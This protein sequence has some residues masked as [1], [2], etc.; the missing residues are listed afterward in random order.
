MVLHLCITKDVVI[1]AGHNSLKNRIQ[2]KSYFVLGLYVQ[3][4]FSWLDIFY[5]LHIG[6]R[7]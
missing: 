6:Q 4:P 1:H 3:L 7:S 2:L 5:V